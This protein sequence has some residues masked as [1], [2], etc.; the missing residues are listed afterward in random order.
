M[1]IEELDYDGNIPK[2]PSARIQG[3]TLATLASRL[4]P[5]SDS[6]LLAWRLAVHQIATVRLHPPHNKH[7]A[8]N[9]QLI[10]VVSSSHNG[11]SALGLLLS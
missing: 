11:T 8:S 2:Q 3:L 4:R 9:K 5:K 1:K 6:A 7:P 10:I